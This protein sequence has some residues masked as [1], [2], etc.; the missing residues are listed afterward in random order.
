MKHDHANSHLSAETLQALLE[1][2]LSRRGTSA[3]EEHLAACARCS[4]ELD[5]WRVLFEDLG[6]LSSHRPHEGFRDRVLAR[7]EM[8]ESSSL[9][10]RVRGR[11][12]ELAS[13]V[14]VA[15]DVL[16]DF[17]E[18]S[19]AARRAERIESHLASCTECAAEADAW[20]GVMHRLDR[21]P[22]FAPSER[23]ADLVIAEVRLPASP[24]W[25]ARLREGLAA[26]AGR[27]PEHVPTGLLQ[28][29]VDG[30]LPTRAVARI[31]AHVGECVVC[32]DEV[33]AWTSVTRQLDGLPR[34]A[35]SEHFRA[36]VL[37]AVAVTGPVAVKPARVEARRRAWSGLASA[38]RRFVPHSRQAWAALSGVA[39]TPV[40]IT[41][42]VAYAVFSHPT[43]TLGSLLSFAW[44]QLSDLLNG[45]A[46]TLSGAVLQNAGGLGVSNLFEMLAAAPLLVAGGV[47]VYTMTSA[48]A[49]RVLWKNLYAHASSA[50]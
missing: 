39:V 21:L 8:P 25:L 3:A 31:E 37:E 22:S 20:M 40:V 28:D 24:T 33:A 19:L 6:D 7:I 12:E 44:W 36:R 16:Q 4:A 17:I 43:L 5:G 27:K 9:G 38:A 50:S 10:A 42:L 18:G 14:H 32:R 23:F 48:L 47:I 29:L 15:P 26:L 49:L 11:L 13:G 35:P 41:G 30:A 46:T 2:E 1:G 34:F 45:A